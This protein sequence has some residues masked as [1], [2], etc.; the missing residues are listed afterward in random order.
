MMVAAVLAG[1][2]GS[3]SS[4]NADAPPQSV[5][6]V[7]CDWNGGS[8]TAQCG[9]MPDADVA[10][11]LEGDATAPWLEINFGVPDDAGIGGRGEAICSPIVKPEVP[12]ESGSPCYVLLFHD[13]GYSAPMMTS[14]QPAHCR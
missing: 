5:D 4:V 13:F 1:C 8:A 3:G 2:G 7:T 10:Q 6:F 11:E 12:C 14:M 9:G